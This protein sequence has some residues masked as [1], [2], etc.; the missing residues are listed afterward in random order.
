MNYNEAVV[1]KEKNSH[2]IGKK[3][4]GATIDELIL[5]PTDEDLAEKVLKLYVQTL[6]SEKAIEPFAGMDVC[7]V[8]VFDKKRIRGQNFFFKT[9]ILNLPDELGVITE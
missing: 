7:I 3:D 9:D 1:L 4:K 2:L 5:V 8:A 6:D